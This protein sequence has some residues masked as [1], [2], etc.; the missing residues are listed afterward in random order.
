MC[1]L[2]D[3]FF[4]SGAVL[5]GRPQPFSGPE[6]V[7]DKD[8][9]LC[10]FWRAVAA[11]PEAV[12]HWADWPVNESDQHAVH[13]WLV[14][15][16]NTFVP[17][18][19]GNPDFYDAKIAG[20]WCWGI[21]CWIGGGWCSGNGPWQV[22]EGKLVRDSSN[23]GVNRQRVHLGRQGQG[24]KR[25]IVHLGGAW[26]SGVGVNNATGNGILNWM[27]ALS[28]RL[29]R[30]RVCCG[31]WSRVMGPSVTEVHGLTG[32]FLD[33]PYTTAANRDAALY[34][35]EDLDIGH[36]VAAWAIANG[37][38]PL[39]RIALCGYE[40]EYEIPDSWD[41]YEWSAGDSY[42]S[43]ASGNRHK[44][45]IWFSPACLKPAVT[46]SLFSNITSNQRTLSP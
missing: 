27:A 24:V 15:Q 1:N 46:L 3:P 43:S 41:N 12:A 20:W 40:G 42:G 23:Q 25:S 29:R 10:N 11:D 44:E 22:V 33:P 38:N 36:A 32:I 7:N 45:R 26:S 21:C 39:L 28:D 9:F 14:G 2:V 31:D 30:V 17:R 19:E 18:L 37:D 4:G 13:A 6:T 8:G 35:E 34:R 5:L 16:R